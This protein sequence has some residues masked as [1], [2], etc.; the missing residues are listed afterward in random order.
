MTLETEEE[1]RNKITVRR[2]RE[3]ANI[4]ITGGYELRAELLL[5]A[6]R[7]ITWEDQ[8]IMNLDVDALTEDAL[9]ENIIQRLFTKENWIELARLRDIESEHFRCPTDIYRYGGF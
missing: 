7:I 5:Y 9:R 8:R 3:D 1:L 4:T 2:I 6:S